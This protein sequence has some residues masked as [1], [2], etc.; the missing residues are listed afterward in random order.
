[1]SLDLTTQL[2]NKWLQLL[3]TPCHLLAAV[4]RRGGSLKLLTVV[5][6][7]VPGAAR[8]APITNATDSLFHPVTIQRVAVAL[9]LL[10]DYCRHGC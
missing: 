7:I 3:A 8:H 5:L 2:A 9:L 1:M 10:Y 6:A 4:F